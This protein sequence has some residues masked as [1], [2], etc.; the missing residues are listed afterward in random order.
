MIIFRYTIVGDFTNNKSNYFMAMQKPYFIAH[1]G[2]SG[3]FPENTHIAFN[4]AWAAGC[5]GIELDI[6]VS[7]D[8]KVIVIHDP[9]TARTA[10]EKHLIKDSN[11]AD[12]QHLDV[13]Q[14][15][16]GGS[17]RFCEK[18]PLLSDVV[19]RMPTEKIIQIEIK[20][21][22]ENM[23]AVI[24]ELSAL[25]A[26]REDIYPQVISFDPDKIRQVKQALPHL[27]CFLVMDKRYPDIT[28]RVGFAVDNT[29]DGLDMD[30]QMATP[31]FVRE[32]LD[33]GLQ[34]AHWT[35]NNN[36]DA[37]RLIAQGAS[38]IAGDFAD[39]LLLLHK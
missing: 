2:L 17:N 38:F 21:Q 27:V 20:H 7:K 31:E 26:L 16:K 25:S 14:G 4:A 5:D 9:D 28:D 35:V 24:A 23:D 32:V 22:I 15:G 18:I 12:L 33:A 19:G 10:G 11:W 13:G 34:V 3:R 36:E 1:R 8:G 6:Q 37:K 29:L 39:E 30:Y